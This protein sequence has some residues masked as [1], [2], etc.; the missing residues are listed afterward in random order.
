[1]CDATPVQFR[2]DW[3]MFAANIVNAAQEAEIQRLLF[4]GSTCIHPSEAQQPIREATLL[5]GPLWE[6]SEWL[7]DCQDCRSQTWPS[8]QK[9]VR[10]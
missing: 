6:T 8:R 1:M 4:P 7:G 9:A 3:L 2:C 10:R 5:T